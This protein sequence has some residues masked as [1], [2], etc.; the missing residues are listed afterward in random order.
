MENFHD[1]VDEEKAK[2]LAKDYDKPANCSQCYVP[3]LNDV[4]W[5][6]L[7]KYAQNTDVKLQRIQ[8]Y[9]LKSMFPVLQL[10]DKLYQ[11]T[12][13]KK[14]LT[15]SETVEGLNLAK[16]AFQLMQV[17]FTDVSFRR[18][19]FLKDKLRAPYKQLCSDSNPV[20]KNLLGD[21][22]E[23]KMKELEVA[24]RMSG[25]LRHS[26]FPSFQ[27]NM[28]HQKSRPPQRF[29]ARGYAPQHHQRNFG[30]VHPI[31]FEHMPKQTFVKPQLRFSQEE[32]IIIDEE[33]IKLINKKVIQLVD[34]C[35]NEYISNIFIRPKKD[36]S[37]RIIF[38][39]KD[40]NETIEYHHFKMDTLKSAIQM[41]T[42]DCWFASVD[43][44]DAYYSVLIDRN[45]RKYLRF[46]WQDCCYQFR[47]LP[48]GLTSSPR[49]FTKLLKP[50]FAM[51]RQNGFNSVIY[52]DDTCLH[53]RTYE[54]CNNNILNTVTMLD[55]LGFTVHPEKSV[56]KPVQEISF[57]GFLLDS[58]KMIVKLL[59][60]KKQELKQ[61]CLNFMKKREATIRQ[62]AQLIGKMVA[63]GPGVTYAS[64]YFKPLEI[65]KDRL[66]K[67]HKGNF[68]SK[69]V[70]TK[71]IREM[72]NWWINN[73]EDSFKH[74]CCREPD[75]I[76]QSDSSGTGWGAIVLETNQKTGGHWSYIEQNSHIN[77]LELKAAFLGIQS[78]CRTMKNVH[79]QIQVDNFVAM[80]YINNM[81]GRKLALNDLTR[82]I[83]E[84]CIHRDI[85]LS[86]VHLPGVQNIHADRLSRKLNDDLEW[87]LNRKLFCQIA[88]V[89]NLDLSNIVDMFAS[90]LNHQVNQYV[91]FLPDPQAIA[92]D[93][94]SI[95]WNSFVYL[96]PPFSVIHRVLQKVEEDMC[97][98]IL[99]AP[100]WSTQSWFPRILTLIVDQSYI[101]PRRKDTLIMPTKAG[102]AHPLDKMYLGCFRLSGDS[103]KIQRYQEMLSKQS[104]LP[105]EIQRKNNIGCISKDGCYFVTNSRLIHLIHL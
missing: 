87:M 21:K 76:L 79:I 95:K 4:V 34:R 105:G 96:F 68:D 59:P 30:R 28:D 37:H 73:I 49:V 80:S 101:I 1:R 10:F 97:E 103:L 20:T 35:E 24:K 8:H 67:E 39:V 32:T 102:K 94:F 31:E 9:Q 27:T 70:V 33:V 42:R 22:V 83:W 47:C 26:E 99:I 40:L 89:F 55:N 77:L 46:L 88:T 61:E 98:A 91:S 38:N 45:H 19:Q 43:L 51:L 66:L 50:V 56:L 6:T 104:V 17:A 41:M 90:R 92:V 52:I 23:E 16:G 2:A 82:N 13:A 72:L 74:V 48:M 25:K 18:R 65:E 85:W 3:K 86:A 14:G 84:W 54:E 100:L 64:L 62:L 29:N 63:A 75:V 11:S 53:G 60:E 7:D 81:G 5:F 58:T 71:D 93:A 36:G 12:K 44:K 69:F 78:F 15:H 57:L